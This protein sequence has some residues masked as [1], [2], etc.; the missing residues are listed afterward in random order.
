M[1]L[2]EHGLLLQGFCLQ[3][4]VKCRSF[5]FKDKITLAQE[6]ERISF[7]TLVSLPRLQDMCNPD[8]SRE[9]ME[10]GFPPWRYSTRIFGFLL[11]QVQYWWTHNWAP[12]NTLLC[13]FLRWA[14]L[15]FWWRDFSWPCSVLGPWIWC[16]DSRRLW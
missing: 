5:Y 2:F 12:Y 9:E 14:P 1:P 10:H 13:N 3:N 11:Q 15:H 16:F 7:T 6:N 4:K 8:F